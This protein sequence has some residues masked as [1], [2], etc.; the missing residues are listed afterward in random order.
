MSWVHPCTE[1]DV[2]PILDQLREHYDLG[3]PLKW[4]HGNYIMPDNDDPKFGEESYTKGNVACAT[5]VREGGM[6]W[7]EIPCLFNFSG[8]IYRSKHYI[9]REGY[10]VDNIDELI[11]HGHLI[12]YELADEN[13]IKKI[14]FFKFSDGKLT[15]FV[16]EVAFCNYPKEK[17]IV[18]YGQQYYENSIKRLLDPKSAKDKSV[19]FDSIHYEVAPLYLNGVPSKDYLPIMISLKAKMITDDKNAAFPDIDGQ[20]FSV[21]IPNMQRDVPPIKYDN[22]ERLNWGQCEC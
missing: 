17:S 22:G 11:H 1:E 4:E 21:L 14:N 6:P 5:L 15:N 10:Q 9:N 18:M 16:P 2:K 13:H 3:T 20:S 12:A 19:K 7:K 8:T